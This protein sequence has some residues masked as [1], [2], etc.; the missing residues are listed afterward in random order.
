VVD[1]ALRLLGQPEDLVFRLA[2]PEGGAGDALPDPPPGALVLR[3]AISKYADLMSP[4]SKAAVAALA[5]CAGDPAEGAALARLASP[6]GA[7]DFFAAVLKDRRGLLDVAAQFPSVRVPIGERAAGRGAARGTAGR[8]AVGCA[9]VALRCALLRPPRRRRPPSPPLPSPP[10]P[11]RRV[12]RLGGAHAPAP[13]LLDRLLPAG[14]PRLGAP[15]RGG[16]EGEAA[17]G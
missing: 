14:P 7:D 8:G 12:L 9:A 11:R 10:L 3:A 16:G 6:A 13:L 4:P 17:R 1:A 5:A 2:K 15:H